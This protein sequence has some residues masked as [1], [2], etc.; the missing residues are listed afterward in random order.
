MRKPKLED[1]KGPSFKD[2]TKKR[3]TLKELQEK[4]YPFLYSDLSGMLDNLFEKGVIKLSEPKRL[5]KARRAIDLSIVGTIGG[6]WP[7]S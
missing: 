3:R 4:K 7:P 5:E 6:R 1:K 2:A